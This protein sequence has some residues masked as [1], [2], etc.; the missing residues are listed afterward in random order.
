MWN[1]IWGLLDWGI[2]EA[3]RYEGLEFRHVRLSSRPVRS[4]IVVE[5]GTSASTVILHGVSETRGP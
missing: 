4:N 5:Q 2:F 3:V 1:A